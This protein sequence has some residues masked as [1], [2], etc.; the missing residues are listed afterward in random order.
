MYH[1]EV[2]QRQYGTN[3]GRTTHPDGL[4]GKAAQVGES[5]A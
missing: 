2:L 3:A 1:D 5:Y 4:I